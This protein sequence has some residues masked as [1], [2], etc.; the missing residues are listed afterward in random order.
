MAQIEL[1][2]PTVK[3]TGER[4]SSHVIRRRDN[5]SGAGLTR[6]APDPSFGT[7]DGNLNNGPNQPTVE[8]NRIPHPPPPKA[9]IAP[10]GNAAKRVSTVEICRLYSIGK[11]EFG[12]S[13]KGIRDDGIPPFNPMVKN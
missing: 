13:C 8:S 1:F 7:C 12:A 10:Q 3:H 2:S 5:S 6:R 11:C 9:T 4:P